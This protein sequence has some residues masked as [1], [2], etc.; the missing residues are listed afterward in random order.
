MDTQWME[1]RRGLTEERIHALDF[2]GSA[3]ERTPLREQFWPVYER[4]AESVFSLRQAILACVETEDMRDTMHP[5]YHSRCLKTAQRHLQDAAGQLSRLAEDPL[6]RRTVEERGP[7]LAWLDQLDVS[8]HVLQCNHDLAATWDT[9]M[10]AY[11]VL[12][13]RV[14]LASIAHPTGEMDQ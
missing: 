11:Y 13:E 12:F 14:R 2:F 4:L 6:V 9:L 3:L 7:G 5:A 1:D 10:N 8:G